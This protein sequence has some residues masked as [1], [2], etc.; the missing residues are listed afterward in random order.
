MRIAITGAN[1]SV[2]CSLL[3]QLSSRPDITAVAG[4]RSESARS[5]LPQGDNIEPRLVS[6]DKSTSLDEAFS[7]CDCVLH[8]AGILIESKTSKYQAANVDAT[9]A[10]V[11]AAKKAGVKRLIFISVVGADSQSR[12]SYFKSK[13]DAE[14]AIMNSGLE[15]VVLRTPIL[16]GP[17]T[18]GAG[19][20]VGMASQPKVKILGGGDYTMRPLDVDDLCNALLSIATAESTDNVIHEL[21]GPTPVKYRDLISQSAKAMGKAV[22]VGAVPILPAK[23]MSA[24][25]STFKGGGMSP[26]VIDVIT[27]DEV[28]AQNA[29]QA[30]DLQL[31]SLEDT[32]KK[33][34][35]SNKK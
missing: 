15:A 31:T 7:G 32:I 21:V 11:E 6:F 17:G 12:N 23:I 18:A 27:M 19:A 5:K 28:V 16:L 25:V 8:L 29:D 10:V 2:G 34:T 22:E 35:E 4:V 9:V 33:F 14:Q 26:T 30:L 20:I 13:G 3:Q 24:V 1:S